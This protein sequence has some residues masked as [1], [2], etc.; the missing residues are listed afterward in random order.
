MKKKQSLYR[1]L[2]EKEY[3][4]FDSYL[5]TIAM[6]VGNLFKAD[7]IAKLLGIS[8][9]KVNKYTELILNHRIVEAIAPWVQDA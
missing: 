6:N 1:E 9:R 5:R 4:I 8:R 2:Y 7:Q 3:A